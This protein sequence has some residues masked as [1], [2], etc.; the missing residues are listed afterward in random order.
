MV[1]N[2]KY[3]NVNEFVDD[4]DVIGEI[5][6]IYK[7][8]EYSLSYMEDGI[9]IAECYKEETEQKFKDID[10]FLDNFMLDGIPIKGLVTELDI[11]FH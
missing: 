4:I 10:D 9:Y 1:P 2:D 7:G 8:K 6:F 3:K 5:V 11:V